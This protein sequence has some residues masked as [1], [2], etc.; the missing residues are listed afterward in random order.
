M[1]FSLFWQNSLCPEED[2]L[3]EP[4][5]PKVYLGPAGCMSSGGAEPL[6]DSAGCMSSGGAEPLTDSAS[7]M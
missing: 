1:T 2:G 5:Q 3:G 6:T 7:E 4:L